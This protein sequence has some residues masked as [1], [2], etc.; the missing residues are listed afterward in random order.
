MDNL[1]KNISEKLGI[2]EVAARK[3]VLIM[4]DYLKGVLPA[5]IANQIDKVLEMD[6]VSEEEL[7]ELG[8]FK[9]P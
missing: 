6:K 3:S 1:V 2:S 5:P 7:R 8:L 4:T 9:M